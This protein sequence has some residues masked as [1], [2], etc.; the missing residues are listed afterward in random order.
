MAKPGRWWK[1]LLVVA[2]VPLFL[3]LFVFVLLDPVVEWQVRRSMEKV[4]VP[5]Y[6]V[7]FDDA[8]LRPLPPRLVLT[9]LKVI[10]DSAGGAEKPYIANDKMELSV[11]GR[12]LLAGRFV[13]LMQITGAHLNF[14]AANNPDEAQLHS[15]VPDMLNKVVA[16]IPLT[17]DRIE[18]RSSELTV[19]DKDSGDIPPLRIH[20]AEGAFENLA[21]RQ[22]V[23]RGAPS[24]Y[25][26]S[27]KVQ[28]TGTMSVFV[29]ADPVEKERYFAG[30]A[31]I[32]DFDLVQ[33]GP[34]F[35]KETGVTIARGSLDVTAE[36]ECRDG[37]I[38]GNVKPVFKN[39][40]L[41]PGK[42]GPG[43]AIN[44]AVADA[45]FKSLGPSGKASLSAPISFQGD[46]DGPQSSLW[47]T[48]A[49][50]VRRSFQAGIAEGLQRAQNPQGKEKSNR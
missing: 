13:G 6:R 27:A 15:E 47:S 21:P 32:A 46:L 31:A 48:L 26:L 18:V 38:T 29:T 8:S 37:K 1:R 9:N 28:Q 14:I 10:K 40:K 34:K 41:S 50:L 36:L 3:A 4:F 23:K 33:L 5:W 45:A 30:Q 49:G 22:A 43:P 19:V 11:R 16:S 24:S 42:P 2:A 20:S 17:V 35:A 25:A 39:L 12:E 7:T 44:A